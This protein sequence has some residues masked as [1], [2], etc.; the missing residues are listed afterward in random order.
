[1][2]VD[3]ASTSRVTRL[4]RRSPSGQ[5][6]LQFGRSQKDILIASHT[7]LARTII[8]NTRLS[9]AIFCASEGLWVPL[10]GGASR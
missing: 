9:R 3:L 7:A 5:R 1:M 10:R 2:G 4:T 6:P 8:S